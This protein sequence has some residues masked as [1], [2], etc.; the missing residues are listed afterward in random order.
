MNKWSGLVAARSVEE[1][2]CE[3]QT[4]RDASRRGARGAALLPMA[5]RSCRQVDA[6]RDEGR[7]VPALRRSPPARPRPQPAR[8]LGDVES[9]NGDE[10]PPG[11]AVQ[12]LT[13]APK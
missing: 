3:P 10:R 6:A 2:E 8:G 4:A 12:L 5:W 1:D 11:P 7:P 13:P 9:R